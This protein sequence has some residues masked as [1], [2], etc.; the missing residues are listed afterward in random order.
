MKK[1]LK[2]TSGKTIKSQRQYIHH[3]FSS[4]KPETGQIWISKA[5][6]NAEFMVGEKLELH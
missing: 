4:H 6:V 2:W 3:R 1:H 5:D